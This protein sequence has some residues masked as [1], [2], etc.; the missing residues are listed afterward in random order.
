MLYVVINAIVYGKYT[1]N[2][3]LGMFNTKEDAVKCMNNNSNRGLI[4]IEEW[5][6]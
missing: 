1:T 4:L 6:V 5:N 2:N 3:V